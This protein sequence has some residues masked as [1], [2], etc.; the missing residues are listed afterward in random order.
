MSHDVS[1]HLKCRVRPTRWHMPCFRLTLN[2]LPSPIL[3]H[4]AASNIPPRFSC[5]YHAGQYCRS[6]SMPLVH[7]TSTVVQRRTHRAWASRSRLYLYWEVP[8]DVA[9]PHHKQDRHA[10]GRHYTTYAC[11]TCPHRAKPPSF[12]SKAQRLH[13]NLVPTSAP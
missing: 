4:N 5:Q 8:K 13:A 7:T 11:R 6:M 9:Y 10:Q 1:K 12:L 3:P 2:F